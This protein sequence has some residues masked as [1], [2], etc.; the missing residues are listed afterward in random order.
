MTRDLPDLLQHFD[1]LIVSVTAGS[2]LLL[3]VLLPPPQKITCTRPQ[4]KSDESSGDMEAFS[5]SGVET[6]RLFWL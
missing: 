5:P 2:A 4:H 6:L 1:G 3:F